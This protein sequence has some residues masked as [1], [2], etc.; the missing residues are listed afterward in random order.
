MSL[1]SERQKLAEVKKKISKCEKAEGK[2]AKA[3]TGCNQQRDTW[4]GSY[5]KLKNN[6]ELKQVKKKDVFEGEMADG[7][8]VRVN[9]MSEKIGNTLNLADSLGS[10]LS[11][12]LNKLKSKIAE[13]KKEKKDIED[14]IAYLEELERQAKAANTVK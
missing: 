9:A 10:S 5:N 4:K 13:L 7:L 3:K 12:Q 11:T 1:S 14:N 2:V 8:S 6:E